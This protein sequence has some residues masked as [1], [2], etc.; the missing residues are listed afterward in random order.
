MKQW[1]RMKAR[2]RFYRKLAKRGLRKFNAEY[3]IVQKAVFA[4]DLISFYVLLDGWF[5]K[6]L[7][8][9]FDIYIM[10]AMDKD[11]IAPGHGYKYWQSQSL[12]YFTFF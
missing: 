6:H 7:L 4:N 1:Y 10:P 11:S 9:Q 3:N 8:E 2:R 12:V 5:E